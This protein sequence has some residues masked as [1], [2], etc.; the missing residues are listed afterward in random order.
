MRRVAL[1]LLLPALAAVVIAIFVTNPAPLSGNPALVA[2]APRILPADIQKD[3][4]YVR[5]LFDAHAKYTPALSVSLDRVQDCLVDLSDASAERRRLC[6]PLILDAL[7]AIDLAERG[8]GSMPLPD[9]APDTGTIQSQIA[10]AAI[11]L[12]RTDWLLSKDFRS[13]PDT[14]ICDVA[15]VQ[16]VS[17]PQKQ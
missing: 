1:N 14:P 17:I 3:G 4:S 13:V 7:A 5:S 16:L 12:C 9:P 2:E 8:R 10:V 15:N 11:D 6:A